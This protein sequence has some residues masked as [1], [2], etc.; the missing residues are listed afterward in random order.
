[1]KKAIAYFVVLFVCLF[2]MSCSEMNKPNEPVIRKADIKPESKA[3]PGSRP[4]FYL[5]SPSNETYRSEN[6]INLAWSNPTSSPNNF[7]KWQLWLDYEYYDLNNSYNDR[8]TE[9]FLEL[10]RHC[11]RI[12]LFGDN[13]YWA[14]TNG[15]FYLNVEIDKTIKGPTYGTPRNGQTWYVET[16]SINGKTFSYNW[17][18]TNDLGQ[19]IC[20]VSTN[21]LSVSQIPTNISYDNYFISVTVNSTSG[22]VY[23]CGPKTVILASS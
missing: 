20:T 17:K 13:Q 23:N 1:M 9:R 14:N 22:N 10:G 3:L 15:V 11:W 12:Y 8:D 6:Y 21:T 19:N 5:T 4:Y 16:E 18:V 7:E 2:I